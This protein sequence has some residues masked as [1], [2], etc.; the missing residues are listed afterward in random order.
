MAKIPPRKPVTKKA[1]P[2]PKLMT[3]A[4]LKAMLHYDPETGVFTWLVNSG[5]RARIGAVAGTYSN[6]YRRLR[7]GGQHYLMHRL[8]FL[9]MTGSMPSLYV[10]HIN[11]V[12]DDN[13]WCNLRQCAFADNTKNAKRRVDNRLDAKGVGQRADGTF[14]ARIRVDGVRRSLGN[15]KSLEEASA[16]YATA[17]EQ[18]HGAFARLS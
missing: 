11:G 3:Q 6:G 9:Y 8:A 12:R 4:E 1:K 14:R 10:D 15:F 18:A 16:A 7:V 17:A 13:R 2:S 5:T